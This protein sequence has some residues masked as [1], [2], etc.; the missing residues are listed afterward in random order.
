MVADDSGVEPSDSTSVALISS[1]GVLGPGIVI[2]LLYLLPLGAA[3]ALSV[4]TGF[5]LA[6]WGEIQV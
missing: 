5:G 1:I 2:L 6:D 3:M 4:V